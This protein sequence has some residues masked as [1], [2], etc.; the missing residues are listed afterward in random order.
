M[1]AYTLYLSDIA[2]AL[3]KIEEFT[4]GMTYDEF[5]HD[6]KTQSAVIRKF[7][8]IGEAA[9]KI[10][11]PVR[12]RYLA[13]PWREMAGMRNKLIHTYFGVDTVLVWR[14]VV[15]RVPELRREICRILD[16]ESRG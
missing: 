13:I 6:D 1:R 14:T 2:G 5:L 9:K 15:N 8:V 3:E 10:P 12:D 16:Q 11:M 4:A 7:E